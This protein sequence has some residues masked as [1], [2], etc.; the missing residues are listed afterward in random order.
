MNRLACCAQNKMSIWALSGLLGCDMQAMVW[1]MFVCRHMHDTAVGL[2]AIDGC[3]VGLRQVRL[4]AGPSQ[5]A[6]LV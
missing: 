3:V 1:A 2:H 6:A 5:D 4:A